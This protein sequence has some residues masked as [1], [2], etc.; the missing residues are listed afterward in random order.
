MFTVLC[1]HHLH[2]VPRHFHHSKKVILKQLL[3]ILLPQPLATKD[4]LSVSMDLP[5]LDIAYKRN[6]T[7]CDLQY[8]ASFT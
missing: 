5:I 6:H 8:L 1:H 2:V 4:L 7:I 3:P